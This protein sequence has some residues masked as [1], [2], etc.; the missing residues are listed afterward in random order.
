M[1]RE[2]PRDIPPIFRQDGEPYFRA[3]ERAELIKLLDARGTIVAAGGGTFA[4]PANRELMLHDGAVV[5]LDVP[6][7]TVLSRI[8]M[9]GRRPLAS[10]RMEMERL[11]N[12]R[13]VAYR[14]GHLRVDAGKG[15]I[16]E[17]VDHIVEW[18]G[19]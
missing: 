16:E 18:L 3:R 5:W 19:T 8:P 1:E 2:D 15:S 9:D 13:L 11:Y 12:L 6:F 17:L 14:Q 10:D 4:D 7:N